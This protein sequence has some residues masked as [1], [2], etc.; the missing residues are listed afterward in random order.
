MKN[1]IYSYAWE[2]NNSFK[3]K[4]KSSPNHLAFSNSVLLK[5]TES[6]VYLP[7]TRHL[8]GTMWKQ[9]AKMCELQLLVYRDT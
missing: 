4:K 6:Y 5:H 1:N 2:I 9:E 3:E 8:L 7:F